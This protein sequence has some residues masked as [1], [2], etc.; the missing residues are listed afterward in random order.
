MAIENTASRSAGSRHAVAFCCDDRYLPYALWAAHQ[1]IA[2][3]ESAAFDVCIC[4]TDTL[5]IP[6]FSRHPRLRFCRIT[7]TEVFH[8]L[9]HDARR[10]ASTYM[11][12]ALP[13]AFEA[14]Y[15][16][17]LY[18]DS[19]IAIEQGDFSTLL[20]LPLG[21]RPVAAIRD[22]TQWRTPGRMPREFRQAGFANAPYF[23]AGVLLMDIAAWQAREVLPHALDLAQ[24]HR[25]AL[26][27]Y[28]QTLLNFA[29]YGN[30]AE[31]SPVWNWQ[32]TRRSR[33]FE[34][35]YGANVI[36]FIGPTKPWSD[37]KRK[38][39]HRFRRDCARFLSRHFPDRA[40][41]GARKAPDV[42]ILWRGM[43]DEAL[44]LKRMDRYLARFPDDMT[45]FT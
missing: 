1:V 31:L 8:G 15:D 19:D 12:L 23:N 5:E 30:W 25:H 35:M 28:D 10:S 33:N 37:P 44:T 36:H 27:R 14:D 9:S 4:H 29:L 39:P 42:G 40:A 7:G 18:L 21:E 17:I 20:D 24:S 43:I 2:L 26:D 34:L 38:L 32:Y 3:D 13:D 45:V 22:N 11:R 41:D 6:D 16:R